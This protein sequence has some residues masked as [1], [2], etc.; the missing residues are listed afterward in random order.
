MRKDC[1]L[2]EEVTFLH[3]YAIMLVEGEKER[4]AYIPVWS[5]LG[6]GDG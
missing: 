3:L 6:M 4:R 2:V 5:E 1:E